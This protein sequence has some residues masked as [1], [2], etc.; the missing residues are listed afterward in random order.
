MQ[1]FFF[2]S[3]F[4]LLWCAHPL[5]VEPHQLFHAGNYREAYLHY[6]SKQED[7]ESLFYAAVSLK[8]MGQ[9]EESFQLLKEIGERF[10]ESPFGEE[11]LFFT[12]LEKRESQVQLPKSSR[13]RAYFVMVDGEKWLDQENYEEA[14]SL[15]RQAIDL[16]KDV[17]KGYFLELKQR[18]FLDLAK[19]ELALGRGDPIHFDYG[20]SLLRQSEREDP[21]L[22]NA[23][24][25]YLF[26]ALYAKKHVPHALKWIDK[27]LKR[28]LDPYPFFLLKLK[29]ELT[30]SIPLLE[31][32]EMAYLPLIPEE[33]LL[34][35]WVTKA[36]ILQE[37]GDLS[38]ALNLLG[39]IINSPVASVKRLEAMVLRQKIFTLMGRID[40]ASRQ[41]TSVQE[42][43]K[44]DFLSQ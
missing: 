8:K 29:G 41:G 13:Y 38:S 12:L 7:P 27:A 32:A 19:V 35:L 5:L 20:L 37:E 16:L 3:S 9:T 34:D 40:L 30:R 24:R 23:E 21:A 25:D 39:T 4:I 22:F 1:E 2:F 36:K 31:K 6:S 26:A 18:A 10:P 11:A 43:G 15:F 44:L 28:T 14:A 42:Y 33:E 17:G